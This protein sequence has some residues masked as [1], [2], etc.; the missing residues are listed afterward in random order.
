[1]TVGNG[2]TTRPVVPL[3]RANTILYCRRWEATVAFYRDPL[4]LPVTHHTDWFVEFHLAAASYLSIADASRATIVQ[5]S[6]ERACSAGA[7]P[8]CHRPDD[9]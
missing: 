3:D 2:A 6:R 1:M 5:P 9:A 4:R 7:L 8:T